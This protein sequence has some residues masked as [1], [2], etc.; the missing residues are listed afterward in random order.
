[1]AGGLQQDVSGSEFQIACGGLETVNLGLGIMWRNRMPQSFASLG[2]S[3]D[4]QR[5]LGEIGFEEP[6]PVQQ[7]AIPHLLAGHD[8]MAQAQTGTGKTAAFGLP[9]VQSLDG[10]KHGPQALVVTPTRELAV[11]VAEAINR[12]GKYR[13]TKVVAVYGG[14]PI[15]R[16]LRALARPVDVVVGTPGRLMDHMRRETLRLDEVRFVVLDEADEM[17]DMGFIEDIETIL[18]ALPTERQTSLFSATLPSRVASLAQQFMNKPVRIAVTP[19]Q[20]TVAQIHQS[21]YEVVP[22]AKLDAVTRILDIEEP[23]SAMIFCRTKVEVDDVTQALQGRGYAA[24]AIHGDLSQ[25]MRE[26]VLGRFRS[27]AA[28][29]L[30]ATD[31]AARGLDIENVSHVINFS[32]PGDPESYVHRIG[33]T[34][35]AGRTG[36][37]ISLVT[38]RERRMLR[39]I[40]R[41][42]GQRLEQRRV[43]SA[44]DVAAAQRERLAATLA[45]II[46]MQELDHPMALVDDLSAYYDPSQIAAAAISLLIQ[47]EPEEPELPVSATGTE[48]GMVRLFINVG[49]EDGLRPND[50]VGAIANEAQIPGKAIGMIEIKDTYAFVEIPE[51][52]VTRVVDAIGHTKM[53]GRDVRVEIA[54][55][56]EDAGQQDRGRRDGRDGRDG[57]GRGR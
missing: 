21:Y 55:P 35:R 14:Q 49:R 37:A 17:L 22:R 43:P 29:L 32:L 30:V 38:P 10:A 2:L 27:G 15:D 3:E 47:A 20:V 56:R 24:E 1:M 6:T 34:G 45:E 36:E 42:V 16:Q 23:T 5:V 39:W 25:M 19:E 40:E 31:V 12:F 46:E 7:E 18:G 11:Q 50:V 8:V 41:A 54:R 28:T 13:S 52:L 57:R 26:R 53:R 44:S 4:I 48:R 33:R 9:I 51:Q